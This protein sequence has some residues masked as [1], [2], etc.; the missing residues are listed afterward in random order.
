MGIDNSL[1][2]GF[3]KVLRTL[4]GQGFQLPVI[5]ATVARNGSV[6]V[7]QFTPTSAGGVDWKDLCEH[8][9]GGRMCLPINVMWVDANGQAQIVEFSAEL[10]PRFLV[11]GD[12]DQRP[13]ED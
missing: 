6:Q 3:E 5:V 4:L 12:S 2:A 1:S 7:G 13:E 11:P 8:R 10:E 9:V